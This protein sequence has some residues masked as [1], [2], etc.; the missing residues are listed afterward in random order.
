MKLFIIASLKINSIFVIFL[1]VNNRRIEMFPDYWKKLDSPNFRFPLKNENDL[2][3]IPS[4]SNWSVFPWGFRKF[5]FRS[6]SD[7][8]SSNDLF[9]Y[10]FQ[11]GL[12]WWGK[13][14][15]NN[16]KNQII[17]DIPNCNRGRLDLSE[18]RT[19]STT[20]LYYAS[21]KWKMLA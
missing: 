16:S 3:N 18:L 17:S 5:Q 6:F 7:L 8:K 2:W 4:R 15:L 11:N 9:Q 12:L 10:I 14:R 19:L 13:H 1:V 20:V 21:K